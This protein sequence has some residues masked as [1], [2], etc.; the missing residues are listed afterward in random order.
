MGDGGDL[1][2]RG[3]WLERGGLIFEKG[4]GFIEIEILSFTLRLLLDL[5]FTC[6]LKC[7]IT[8][9]FSLMLLVYFVL[10]KVF[11]TVF[12]YVILLAYLRGK[13]IDVNTSE[14]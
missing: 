10:L 12:Y 3:P 1:G 8:C 14:N 7:Y 4:S 11:L 13:C 6:R 2:G 9:Y 5:L